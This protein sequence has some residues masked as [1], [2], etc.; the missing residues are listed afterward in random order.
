M[1]S[2]IATIERTGDLALCD[3]PWVFS[4]LAFIGWV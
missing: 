2:I 1:K 3:Q 4:Y